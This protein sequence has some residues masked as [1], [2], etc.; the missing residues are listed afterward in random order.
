MHMTLKLLGTVTTS[1]IL[2]TA[3]VIFVYGR[4]QREQRTLLMGSGALLGLLAV[5]V[6]WG[7][8]LAPPVPSHA[9]RSTATRPSISPEEAEAQFRASQTALPTDTAVQIIQKM[10]C[11]VC[12]KIPTIPNATV[13]TRGPVLILRTTAPLRLASPEYQALVR[14]GLAHATTPKEYVIESIVEPGAFIVPGYE[15]EQHPNVTPM[16]PH[17]RERFTDEALGFLASFLLMIDEDEARRE[18]LLKQT[19]AAFTPPA[20]GPHT[21]D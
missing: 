4:R 6:L 15:A 13:G 8:W 9:T 19:P 10:G 7:L 11:A 12:H 18:G 3:A 2:I 1:I 21:P 14:A 20:T 5:V 16:Y 17:Y